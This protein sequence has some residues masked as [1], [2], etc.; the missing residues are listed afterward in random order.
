MSK[1]WKDL[2]DKSTPIHAEALNYL[3]KGVEDFNELNKV[4]RGSIYVSEP[5]VD[6]GNTQFLAKRNGIVQM[7]IE[8]SGGDPWENNRYISVPE[9][10]NP[11]GVIA[12]RVLTDSGVGT[13]VLSYDES[14]KGFLI[15]GLGNKPPE[16][17]TD[18][19]LIISIS[20][21]CEV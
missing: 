4:V 9:G 7:G 10:F 18:S 3:Q 12:P 13:V 11:I 8:I 2:P 6:A 17:T 21:L 19:H 5:W 20:Y 1:I 16:W 14:V 15:A